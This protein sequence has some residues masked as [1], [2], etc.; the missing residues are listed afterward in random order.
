MDAPRQ[1]QL[2]EGAVKSFHAR[3][4]RKAQALFEEAAAGPSR[5]MAHSARLHARIC[6]QRLA[7]PQ[8]RLETAEDHYN[9]AISLINQGQLELAGEHLGKALQKLPGADYIHYAMA[10]ARGLSGDMQRAAEHMKRAIELQPRNRGL[11]RNDPDFD[12]IAQRSPMRELLF[13]ER[14]RSA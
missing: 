10:L 9:Y 6:H 13:P 8:L 11:A 2:F 3:D 5:A 1:T 4:F 12:E 7:K 14:T